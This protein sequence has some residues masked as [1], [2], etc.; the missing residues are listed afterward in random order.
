MLLTIISHPYGWWM[1]LV[2]F[3]YYFKRK[4]TLIGTSVVAA[5]W[6]D[7]SISKNNDL[8]RCVFGRR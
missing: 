2:V 7:R 6:M 3:V 4:K 8:E 1:P 5:V